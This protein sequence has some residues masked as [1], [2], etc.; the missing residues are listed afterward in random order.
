MS[1]KSVE[2]TVETKI[3][4]R[5]ALRPDIYSRKPDRI[6]SKQFVVFTIMGGIATAVHY[7]LLIA[8]VEGPNVAPVP[9]SI[10][11]YVAGAITGYLLNYYITFRSRKCH[12]EAFAKF[13]LVAI[14]GLGINTAIMAI[15]TGWLAVHYI[16]SQMLATG[17]TLV[18]NFIA[19][20]LWTF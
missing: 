20:R 4:S 16:L 17:L 18:W 2:R 14:L 12:F 3:G 9:A 8:L 6:L 15:G 1:G 5:I 13:A 11:G 7:L 10:A 19:N